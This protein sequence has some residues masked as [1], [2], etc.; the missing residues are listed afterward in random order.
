MTQLLQ[1]NGPR[2]L[3][4]PFTSFVSRHQQNHHDALHR[5]TTA[6]CQQLSDFTSIFGNIPLTAHFLFSQ[7]GLARSADILTSPVNFN[8][9]RMFTI[10]IGPYLYNSE[11]EGRSRITNIDIKIQY[12]R[13][14]PLTTLNSKN[15]WP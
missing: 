14:S 11:H 1:Q 9:H 7:V 6:H 13:V 2:H 12:Y 3:S 4:L 10:C 8:L 5:D 15:F